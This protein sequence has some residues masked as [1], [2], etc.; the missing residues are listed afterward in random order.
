VWLPGAGE[1]VAIEQ[2]QDG[3]MLWAEA[4]WNSQ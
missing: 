3:G 2:Q 1:G 4:R